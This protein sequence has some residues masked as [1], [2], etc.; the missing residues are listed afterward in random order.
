MKDSFG[1]RLQSPIIQQLKFF[2]FFFFFLIFTILITYAT[3]NTSTCTICITYNTIRLLALL[4][5]LI[6]TL[7]KLILTLITIFTIYLDYFFFFNY[8]LTKQKPYSTY[9]Q[10]AVL[11]IHITNTTILYH[12]TYNTMHTYN[13]RY[14]TNNIV[15]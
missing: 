12:S 6:L 13:V 14:A 7:T 4:T 5:I 2:F 9:L 1:I 8:L 10:C 3:Y 15:L 11:T